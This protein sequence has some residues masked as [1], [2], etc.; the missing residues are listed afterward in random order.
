MYVGGRGTST[1]GTVLPTLVQAQT[2]GLI[3]EIRVAATTRASIEDLHGRLVRINARMGTRVEVVGYPTGN[4]RDPSAYCQALEEMPRPS[5]AMVVVPDHLHASITAD[6]IRAGV[7]PLV[8]KPIVIGRW[9]WIAAD[10]FIAP[11]VSIGD[12]TVVGARSSV[13]KDLP[14]WVVAAGSPAKPVRERRLGPEDFAS[15]P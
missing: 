15:G 11:G 9:C 14:G 2:Q 13:F 4:G 3:G 5:C 7:H 1:F 6:V 8:V 12:G 10:V